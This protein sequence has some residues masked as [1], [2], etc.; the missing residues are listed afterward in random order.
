MF[1]EVVSIVF[2]RKNAII[3]DFELINDTLFKPTNENDI[4]KLQSEMNVIANMIK[5]HVESGAKDDSSSDKYITEYEALVK[6]YKDV[7][8][9]YNEL[10]LENEKRKAKSIELSLFVKELKKHAK[11]PLE[12]DDTL[13]HHV[14]DK[15]LVTKDGYVVFKIKN[16]SE[17]KL[18]I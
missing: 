12:F 15:C 14:V 2:N 10:I 1:L 8:S 5:A 9:K 13:F 7:E 11:L 6:R 4:T 16:G 18:E 3:K 17:I